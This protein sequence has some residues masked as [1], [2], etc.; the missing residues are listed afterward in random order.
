[1]Y[2]FLLEITGLQY[3]LRL[4]GNYLVGMTT[5]RV[6]FFYNFKGKQGT[7]FVAWSIYVC[8]AQLYTIGMYV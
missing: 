2:A 3:Y 4:F 1:M 5:K 6:R 8:N 7:A